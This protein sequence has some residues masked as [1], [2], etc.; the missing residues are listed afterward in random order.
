MIESNDLLRIKYLKSEY[1]KG[2]KNE[3]MGNRSAWFNALKHELEIWDD[4]KYMDFFPKISR[5]KLEVFLKTL[6]PLIKPGLVA[7][8]LLAFIFA[9]NSFT[10]PLIL[11]GF[12]IQTLT[13][14]SLRYISSETVHYGQVAVAATVAVLP[15]II[16]CLFI[17]KHLVRGLSFGAVKG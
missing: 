1:F 15:E 16:A 14:T 17:Q 7:S 2:G 5:L 13:I 10:F 4:K 3:C 12:K 8:G 11:S 6:L 9:W